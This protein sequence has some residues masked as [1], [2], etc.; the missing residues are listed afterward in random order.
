MNDVI[1]KLKVDGRSLE[2]YRSKYAKAK[3]KQLREFGYSTL[4]L[5][6]VNTQ[7]DQL[8]AGKKD[9]LTIIGMMMQDEIQLP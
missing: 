2:A 7:I 5:D 8:L 4:T 9:G 1:L 3:F 6:E